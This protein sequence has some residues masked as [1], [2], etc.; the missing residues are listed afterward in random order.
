MDLYILLIVI[1]TSVIQSIFGVG[2]LLFGTPTL[3]LLEYSFIES[4]LI[5]LPI[6]LIINFFQIFNNIKNI[7]TNIYKNI[8]F[9]CVPIIILFLIVAS[10]L[11]EKLNVLIGCFLI[12]I[13]LKEKFH[14]IKNLF[15]KLLKS[16]K[17]F[18]IAMGAIHGL[19][20]LGGSLLTAKIFSTKISKDKK[21]TTIAASYM[22]F[23]A[24]Q[25]FSIIYMDFKYDLKNLLYALVGILI[26]LVINIFFFKKLSNTRYENLFSIFL[27]LSGIMILLKFLIW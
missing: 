24:F 4:L 17:S 21:R 14:I 10:N 20:N 12:L 18:Y 9:L 23:A 6:S 25:I 8:I 26:Y 19:T 16:E 11:N 13:S 15:A 22:T 3:L 27:F 1:I 7:E 2:V 5:L